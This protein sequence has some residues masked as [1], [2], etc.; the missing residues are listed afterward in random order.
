MKK[1]YICPASASVRI[2]MESHLLGGSTLSKSGG[3]NLDITPGT[4]DFEVS[5][6]SNQQDWGTSA[7]NED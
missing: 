4:A 7:W 3:D 6:Q 5:I 2:S 1:T